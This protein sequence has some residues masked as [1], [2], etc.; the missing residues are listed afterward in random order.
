MT[1]LAKEAVP[2]K[3]YRLTRD[4]GTTYYK[5][6]EPAQVSRLRRRLEKL[7]PRTMRPDDLRSWQALGLCEA[8]HVLGIRILRFR[9]D[10]GAPRESRA[11]VAFPPD[12]ALR[13]VEKPP[14]YAGVRNHSTDRAA[15]RKIT[16]KGVST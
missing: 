14:G 1:V 13:E 6:C 4:G 12:Y 3:I 11:Y 7:N 16:G 9:D 10:G 15:G 8:G 2:G 5:I